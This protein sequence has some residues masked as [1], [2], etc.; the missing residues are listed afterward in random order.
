M[1]R[2]KKIIYLLSAVLTI[3]VITGCGQQ[4]SVEKTLDQTNAP[5]KVATNATFVPFE[6]KSEEN[7]DFAG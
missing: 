4:K 5:L 6:F 1:S 7:G 2:K 3:I